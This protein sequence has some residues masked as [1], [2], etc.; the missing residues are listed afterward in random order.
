MF[1]IY[2]Y[3]IDYSE[4]YNKYCIHIP[5]PLFKNPL[6]SKLLYY[7]KTAIYIVVK[8]VRY[9]YNEGFISSYDCCIDYKD[10]FSPNT[11]I[12]V[13]SFSEI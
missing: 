9:L 11:G 6:D 3:D 12:D 1:K 7:N 4:E 13:K 8:L 5:L 2:G 10:L